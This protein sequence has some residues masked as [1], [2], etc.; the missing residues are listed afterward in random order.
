[1]R[2]GMGQDFY[3]NGIIILHGKAGAP[4]ASQFVLKQDRRTYKVTLRS[5]RTTIVAVEK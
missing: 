4:A 3:C 2:W 1:M 5:F